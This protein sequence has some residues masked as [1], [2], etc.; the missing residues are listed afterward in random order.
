MAG[1]VRAEINYIDKNAPAPTTYYVEPPDGA[2]ICS[3]VDDP[4]LV[5]ITDVRDTRR[6]FSIDN[7]GF[8]FIKL[9]IGFR[10]FDDQD[11][12]KARLYPE[13]KEV[14][15]ALLGRRVAAVFD[16]AT[17]RRPD[18]DATLRGGGV[19]RQPLHRA[20]C[21]FTPTSARQQIMRT[22]GENGRQ[23]LERPFA[24]VNYWRPI[25]GPLR[26]D[27]LAICA[28]QSVAPEDLVR[29]RHVYSYGESEIYGV[30]HN[31][32]HRWYYMS[33]MQPDDAIF[34]KVYD[35]TGERPLVAPHSAFSLPTT[36]APVPPRQSFE[37]RLMVF[38]D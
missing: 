3:V 17:R 34:F 26:D 11:A 31:P 20:H 6:S 10:D 38:Y 30:A 19:S 29:V 36:N 35:E 22:L 14:T 33:D 8:D 16:H 2:Q 32:D 4:Q 25:T 1:P 37:I 5:S 24:L 7:D 27:P 12:V 18:L 9:P 21:D 23:W 28:P 13:M 15:E